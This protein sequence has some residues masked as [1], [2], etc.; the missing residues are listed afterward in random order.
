MARRDSIGGK[1]LLEIFETRYDLY[2][3]IFC[4]QCKQAEWHPRLGSGV[5]ADAIMDRIVY[6]ADTVDL[7]KVN[8]RELLARKSD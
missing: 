7:G 3:T 8:M 4:T 1:Y 2:P 5:M 6:N